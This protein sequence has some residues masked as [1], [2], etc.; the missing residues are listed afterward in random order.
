M[1]TPTQPTEVPRTEKPYTF[2]RIL[3]HTFTGPDNATV[4]IGRVLWF[5]GA[6]AFIAISAFFVWKTGQWN[7]LE[8][9]SGFAAVNGGS[10]AGIKLKE[11]SEP[12]E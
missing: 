6:I 4:D 5:I 12:S 1:T 8:W 11:K 2:K 7:P 10:A 3:R 9:G